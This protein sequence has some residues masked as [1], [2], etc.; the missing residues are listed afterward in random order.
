M[1]NRDTCLMIFVDKRPKFP[2]KY[3][4]YWWKNN[5]DH[6]S[7]AHNRGWRSIRRGRGRYRWRRPR[8]RPR[9]RRAR[10]PPRGRRSPPAS[11]SCRSGSHTRVYSSFETS[12]YFK[13]EKWI[14]HLFLSW[15]NK[16]QSTECIIF[17]H[18]P[19]TKVKIHSFW[20]RIMVFPSNTGI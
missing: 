1:W 12:I 3:L 20:A 14:F 4:L 5:S 15:G 9:S 19:L 18:P 17:P 10:W 7:P 8:P 2:I 6:S 13:H 11:S 16:I